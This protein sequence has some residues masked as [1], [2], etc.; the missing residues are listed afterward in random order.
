[1]VDKNNHHNSLLNVEIITPENAFSFND[2]HMVLLPGS[3][4]EFGVLP[5]HMPMIVGLTDGAISLYV[6]NHMKISRLNIS[7]GFC[8]VTDKKIV[9]LAERAEELPH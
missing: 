7:A 6:G 2:I 1:M 5:G 4:G 3:E 9:I 8:E